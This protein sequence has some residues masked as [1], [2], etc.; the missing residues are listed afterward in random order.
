MGNR[1]IKKLKEFVQS[2]HFIYISLILILGVIVYAN[3]FRNEFVYDDGT[4]VNNYIKDW[5]NFF[6]LFSMDVFCTT[7][8]LIKNNFPQEIL[9]YYYRPL[10]SISY[11]CDYLLWKLNPAG[12]HLTNLLWHLL[13]AMLVYFLVNL[14][15][16][17]VLT[18]RNHN[19]KVALITGLLFVIHPIH[20]EAVT[21][22][23]GRTDLMA[24]SFIL[25]AFILYIKYVSARTF[26]S[27]ILNGAKRNEPACGRQGIYFLQ[28]DSSSPSTKQKA[29]EQVDSATANEA[30]CPFVSNDKRARLYYAGSIFSFILALLSKETAIMFPFILILYDYSLGRTSAPK[31]R[32]KIIYHYSPFFIIILAYVWL[33][34]YVLNFGS[35][36]QSGINLYLRGLTALKSIILYIKLLFLPF[37][38]HM[39]R[40]IDT[41]TSLL[42]PMVLG[43]I[44][45]LIIIGIAIKKAYNKNYKIVLFGAIWFLIFFIPTSQIVASLPRG[46]LEHWAYLPSIGIFMILAIGILKMFEL[47]SVADSKSIIIPVFTV[48][49]SIYAGLS[50]RQNTVWEN[51]ITLNQNM[52]KYHPENIAAQANLGNTYASKGMPD[53]AIRE[54][55]KALK[56]DPTSSDI[57]NNLA[58][59]YGNSGLFDEA[60]KELEEALKLNPYSATTYSNI[61][62]VYLSKGLLDDAIK[63][64]KKALI[65][66]PNYPET[67]NNLGNTYVNKGN[68]DEAI[69]E[70]KESLRLNPI[71]PE[72][73]NNLGAVYLKKGLLDDAMGEFRTT[74]RLKPNYPEAHNNIGNVYEKKGMQDEALKEYK[75]AM[76][77]NPRLAKT[78]NNI[79][80]V[81]K[82]KGLLDDAM[83]E[84]SKALN[85]DSN[86]VETHSNLADI[87]GK[88]ELF[89]AAITEYKKIFLLTPDCAEAHNNIGNMY[90]TKGH[91]NRD[92]IYTKEQL[93]D[94]AIKEYKEALRLKPDYLEA[95]NNLGNVYRAK[96]MLELAREEYEKALGIDP[97]NEA[98]KQNLKKTEER[99]NNKKGLRLM[100]E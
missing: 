16:R 81:Y 5:H 38:L 57:H 69:K 62:S 2:K 74:L 23:S 65:L 48:I 44:A 80:N 29:D 86:F 46:M 1:I 37:D 18:L 60:M 25:L 45:L 11:M 66:N 100:R 96:G 89:D 73:H 14:I 34:L 13:T 35:W 54:Y 97:N 59:V 68:I 56:I 39:D 41:A 71:S 49:L 36:P 87:Y 55:K 33:R 91:N 4:L 72:T 15:S 85:L 24:S 50:I 31:L 90:A 52:L 47:P 92:T 27:V 58:S 67:H 70:Y 83:K 95:Y 26:P 51:G 64:Y 6:K 78:Y 8:S 30:G 79:G 43:S 77:L 7:K 63:E 22:I 99:I 94:D 17:G 19:E 61:G 32:E 21:Y 76:K 84:Y 75:E 82:R 40:T 42:N 10:Q 98:V 93:F 53:E 20:T 12:Y 3:S 28:R 9:F 88:K